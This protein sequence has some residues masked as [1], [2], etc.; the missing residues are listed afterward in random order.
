MIC[1]V[2]FALK[3]SLTR[4]WPQIFLYKPKKKTFATIENL[5][6]GWGGQFAPLI[7]CDF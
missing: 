7:F 5:R 6:F 1:F 3:L 4:F 2:A